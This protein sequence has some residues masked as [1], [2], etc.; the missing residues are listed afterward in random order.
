MKRTVRIRAV[1]LGDADAI[2][3]SALRF[4]EMTNAMAGLAT[5]QGLPASDTAAQGETIRV[6]VTFWRVLKMPPHTMHIETL[7]Q[8]RRVI[9]SREYSEGINRWDHRLKIQSFC[10]SVVWTDTVEIEAGWRT[11]FVA[12]FAAWMYSRRHRHRSALKVSR[13]ISRTA[14]ALA[15]LWKARGKLRHRRG[16]AL[17]YP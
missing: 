12:H 7:D 14:L 5:Y 16:K 6:S 15:T 8:E 11:P 1:Y 2:F 13:Q 4:S 3:A 10:G 9:Q 17:R